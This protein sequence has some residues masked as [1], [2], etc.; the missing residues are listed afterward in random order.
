MFGL[1]GRLSVAL[2]RGLEGSLTH[3]E[4]RFAPRDPLTISRAAAIATV[5]SLMSQ[6]TASFTS[7]IC[8]RWRCRDGPDE[9]GREGEKSGR[10]GG[11]GAR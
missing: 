5:E 2:A 6:R 11:G 3:Y 9:S 8:G 7:A 1:G 4:H 10:L